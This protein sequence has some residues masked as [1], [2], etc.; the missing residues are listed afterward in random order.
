MQSNLTLVATKVGLM[1]GH[2]R[3]QDPADAQADAPLVALL[4]ICYSFAVDQLPA[5]LPIHPA[6]AGFRPRF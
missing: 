3:R 2:G 4:A 5:T 6:L 1:R